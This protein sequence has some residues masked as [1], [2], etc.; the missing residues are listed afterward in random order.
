MELTGLDADSGF[1]TKF[2]SGQ[3]DKKTVTVAQAPF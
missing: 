3:H 1:I 2:K